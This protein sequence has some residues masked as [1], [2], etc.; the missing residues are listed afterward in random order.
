MG[1]EGTRDEVLGGRVE[2]CWLG[3]RHVVGWYIAFLFLYM[4]LADFNR[5]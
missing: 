2:G 1:I 4:E 5:C 3:W